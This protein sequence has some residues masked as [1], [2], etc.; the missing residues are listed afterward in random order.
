MAEFSVCRVATMTSSPAR[1]MHHAVWRHR[2]EVAVSPPRAELY[3]HDERWIDSV[4][5]Q[6]RFEAT[7]FNSDRGSTWEVVSPSG[8]PGAGTISATGLYQAPN[9]GALASGTTD[10]VVATAR[11][12]PLRKAYAWVTLLGLGPL[13]AP[14]PRIEIWPKHVTLYCWSPPFDNAYID[15][16]NKLQV[17][18]AFPRHAANPAVAWS[19]DVGTVIP[20]ATDTT[21]CTFLAP[22]TV[23]SPNSGGATVATVTAKLAAGASA[24]ARIVLLNYVWPNPPTPPP[25]Y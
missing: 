18:R 17:F 25:Y 11:D 7:V 2:V 12:D 5:T 23:A 21:W 4:N 1:V 13:P 20:Y 15:D 19:V 16:S 6:L 14:E 10:I 9:K 24:D 22:N 8:G 3:F